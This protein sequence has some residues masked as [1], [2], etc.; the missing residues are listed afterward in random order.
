MILENAYPSH[1]GHV[2][3]VGNIKWFFKSKSQAKNLSIESGQ[4][5]DDDGGNIIIVAL[6][7]G[8]VVKPLPDAISLGKG[9]RPTNKSRRFCHVTYLRARI[10]ERG[11]LCDGHAACGAM[12]SV[13]MPNI[14]RFRE[15]NY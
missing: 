14:K 7:A 11:N 8:V 15:D 9:G 1:F 12:Q 4:S 13:D 3:S 5:D 6:H 10:K 2:L